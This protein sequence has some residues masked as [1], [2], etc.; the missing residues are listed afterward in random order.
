VDHLETRLIDR[1]RQILAGASR[2]MRIGLAAA[3]A[4]PLLSCSG[5]KGGAEEDGGVAARVDALVARHQRD[6]YAPGVSVAIIRAGRDTLVFR[7]YGMANL[8]T[9]DSASA[10][11]V[12]RIGSITKQFTAVAVMQL[13]EQNRLSLDDSIGRHLP[14]LPAAWRGVRIHQLLNHTAGIPSTFRGVTTDWT[15]IR[16][17]I[18]PDSVFTLLRGEPLDFAPGTAFRYSNVGYLLLGRLIE[19]VSGQPYRQYLQEKIFRPFGLT[20]TRYCDVEPVIPDRAAGYELHDTVLVNAPYNSMT[21][22]F[23]AGALCSTVGDLAAWN[24]ALHTGRVVSPASWT[25]MTTPEAPAG[26]YGFGLYM[27]SPHGHR[28]I[29]HGGSIEGFQAMSAWFPADSLSVTL[30]T[31]LGRDVPEDLFLDIVQAARGPSPSPG[32]T[33]SA[34]G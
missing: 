22:P 32:G 24:R 18:T 27:M 30:L 19:T 3:A 28:A 21:V 4:L 23:S 29:A 15:V 26:R 13:A 9:G 5:A 31:N 16:D 7:G 34:G 17:D 2:G 14:A 25:R 6:T 33:D 20:A 10:Q 1:L 8:E 12:Y 11:T